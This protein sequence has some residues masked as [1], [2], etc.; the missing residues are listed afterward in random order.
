MD[1]ATTPASYNGVTCAAFAATAM[2][3]VAMVK[4]GAKLAG[5]DLSEQQLV[6]CGYNGQAMNG[7]NGA[8]LA[9]YTDWFIKNRGGQGAHENTYKYKATLQS[10]PKTRLAVYKTG[11]KINKFIEVAKHG[12][13]RLMK[14]ISTYGSAIVGMRASDNAFGNYKSGI[15][16]GCSG[17]KADHAVLAVGYGTDAKGNKYWLVKNSWGANWGEKGYFRIQ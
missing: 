9:V 3:E 8:G 7:C 1:R 10:C 11:K 16:T 15:F 14:A 6:D 13:A 17:T 5:L 12:E 4:A 2:H